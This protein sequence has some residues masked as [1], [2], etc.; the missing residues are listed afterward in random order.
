M[1]DPQLLSKMATWRAK[2]DAGTLTLEEMR[3][4]IVLMRGGRFAAV[5]SSDQAKRTS[6]KAAIKPATDLLGELMNMGSKT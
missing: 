2:A 5:R 3:E 4:A 6:A 1:I